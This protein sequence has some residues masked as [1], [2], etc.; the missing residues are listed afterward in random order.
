MA[1]DIADRA[2]EKELTGLAWGHAHS[3]I[4]AYSV[5][6]WDTALSYDPK[7]STGENGERRAWSLM[8]SGRTDDAV[9]QADEVKGLR[10]DTPRL[11]VDYAYLCDAIG[12]TKDSYKWFAHAVKDL[13]CNAIA[14][15]RTDPDLD[16]M[17]KAE[18]AAFEDLVKV[19]YDWGVNR[20]VFHDDIYVNNNSAYPLTNVVFTCTITSGGQ[21]YN[22]VLKADVIQPGTAYT[23][24]NC[25]SISGSNPN[26]GTSEI[27]C[28][29]NK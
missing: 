19:K 8:A 17:R 12:D 16:E 25:V 11:A 28:D 9:K 26:Y 27:D 18:S 21:M 24:N 22:P 3:S 5:D 10:R 20:G 6:V 7:D 15:A 29:Q 1:G 2:W 4:A 14:E 23:W 13:H